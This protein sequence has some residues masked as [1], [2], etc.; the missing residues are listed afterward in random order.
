MQQDERRTGACVLV[1]S[2]AVRDDPFVF[3]EV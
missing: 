2:G 1:H 3:I